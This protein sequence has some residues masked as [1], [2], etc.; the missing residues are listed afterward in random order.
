M[1]NLSEEN[2]RLRQ[3]LRFYADEETYT[4][5]GEK[6]YTGH[7]DFKEESWYPIERDKG[8]TARQQ[9]KGESK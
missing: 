1:K 6:F 3:A 2:D 9:L 8:K 5:T 4:L 7:G